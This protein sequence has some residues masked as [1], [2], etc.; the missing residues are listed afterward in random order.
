MQPSESAE[1]LNPPSN[2][3]TPDRRSVTLCAPRLLRPPA[4]HAYLA[5]N[6]NQFN[7]LVRPDVTVFRLG[8]RAIAFDRLELDACVGRGLL[9]VQRPFLPST[10][11]SAMSK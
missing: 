9:S 6:K 10:G 5:M 11:G 4:A 3:G 2:D 7:S 1:D 8:K